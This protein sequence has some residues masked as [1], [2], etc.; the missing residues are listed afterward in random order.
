MADSLLKEFSSP[1]RIFISSPNRLHAS[2]FGRVAQACHLLGKVIR[3]CNEPPTNV[4]ATKENILLLSQT[5]DTLLDLMMKDESS[6]MQFANAISLCFRQ[7][8]SLIE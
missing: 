4:A 7:V 2:P 1:E 5:I 3:H 8:T 6:I